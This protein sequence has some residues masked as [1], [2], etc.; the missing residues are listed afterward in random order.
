MPT[1]V[2]EVLRSLN[3]QLDEYNYRLLYKYT[4]SDFHSLNLTRINIERHI[5]FDQLK[6][7]SNEHGSQ[8]YDSHITVVQCNDILSQI[9]IYIYI[10]IL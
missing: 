5:F 10:N 1:E 3:V 9:N 7:K 6:G 2:M 8:A 4:N